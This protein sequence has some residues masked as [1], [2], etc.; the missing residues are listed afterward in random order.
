MGLICNVVLEKKFGSPTVINDGVTIAKEI[1]LEDRFENMGAQLIREVSSKTNDLAG[2]G[3]TTVLLASRIEDG[4]GGN[5]AARLRIR[6]ASPRRCAERSVGAP[7]TAMSSTSPFA[8][9]VNATCT[10]PPWGAL[11]THVRP[12]A[13]C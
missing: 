3:T 8:R 5:G 6:T 10:S 2:D 12:S 4:K 11:V 9:R 7:R 1:E 13:A